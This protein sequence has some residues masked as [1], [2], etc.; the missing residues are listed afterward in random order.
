T[1]QRS[2]V[3]KK[4]EPIFV[5]H[6]FKYTIETIQNLAKISGFTVFKDF[7][8]SERTFVDSLWIVNRKKKARG[9]NH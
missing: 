2:F 3:F 9:E 4:W 1:L 5:E 8:D 7:Y 6:S